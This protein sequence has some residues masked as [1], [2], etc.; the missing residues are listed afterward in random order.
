MRRRRRVL[1]KVVRRVSEVWV[2]VEGN[3]E[4]GSGGGGGG[5]VKTLRSLSV[6]GLAVGV[7][8]DTL[9]C[10]LETVLIGTR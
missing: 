9:D 10:R 1:Q 5:S 2:A 3:D 7:N 8:W 4:L 6:F